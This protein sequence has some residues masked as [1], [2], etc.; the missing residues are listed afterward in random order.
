M[1][2]K[3]KPVYSVFEQDEGSG[4]AVCLQEGCNA[5]LV[6]SVW[7]NKYLYT[8]FSKLFLY[9]ASGEDRKSIA[10]QIQQYKL[11]DFGGEVNHTTDPTEFW[12]KRAKD[13]NDSLHELALVALTII[14]CP[15]T[16]VT[17]ERL[18]SLLGFV[19]NHLRTC[20]KMEIL[21]DILF[22]L[23]N[24]NK[25]IMEMKTAKTGPETH[26]KDQT[27]QRKRKL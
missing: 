22:C 12:L 10:F 27:N 7:E 23:W 19:F 21:D 14:T 3:L 5:T 25:L 1:S 17:A 18:F 20:L 9:S 13:E 16:E 2:S 15:V 24:K 6:V 4:R 26:P 11:G 8:N